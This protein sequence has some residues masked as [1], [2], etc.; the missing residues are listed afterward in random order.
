M[1]YLIYIIPA[2]GLLGV[3]LLFGKLAEVR[4]YRSIRDRELGVSEVMAVTLETLDFPKP[5]A[6]VQLARGAV[7]ISVDHWKR[8]LSSLRM[9]FGGEMHSYASLLDRARREALLRMYASQPD[10]DIY[11][12]TRLETSS[13][14]KGREEKAVGCVE[15]L[16][17]S[18]AVWLE[19]GAP[20][21]APTTADEA[22]S[23]AAS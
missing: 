2:L 21:R 15:V 23:Q 9:F 11:L 17:Y 19:D 12:N 20:A 18:T 1:E 10:A 5:V 7:V 4:H 3:G 13:I 16:A 6:R 22:G 14:S 8:F